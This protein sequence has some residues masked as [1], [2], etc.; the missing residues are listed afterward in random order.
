MTNMGDQEP[1]REGRHLDRIAQN[2]QYGL[3]LNGA[4]VE[5]SI[6]LFQ[7][8][9]R[10]GSVLELGP[11]DGHATRLLLGADQHLEVLE[12]S[13]E[14][15]T[16]LRHQY[17]QLTVHHCLFE[18]F[19]PL[20]KYENIILSHVLEHVEDPETV[21]SLVA[22][23]LAPGGTL[24]AATPNALSFHRQIGVMAGDLECETDL[25]DADRLIGHRRVFD[26]SGLRALVAGSGLEVRHF[27]GYFLKSLSN[28]QIERVVDPRYVR[29]LMA[30]G[31]RV[32]DFAAD[33]YVVATT[34]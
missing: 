31:E 3:G 8:W 33:I 15:A 12:G 28:A 32:P 11:A 1:E 14:F 9:S 4:M 24:F 13:L 17:P 19:A 34:A 29:S 21:M 25:N 5:Y 20:H 6:D 22:G 23:W 18:E 10:P 16:Q 27:G 26:G 2:A 30:A 7:R